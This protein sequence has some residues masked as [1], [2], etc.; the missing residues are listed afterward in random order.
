MKTF[1]D[2][3]KSYRKQFN[4]TQ[5][6]FADKINVSS[7][8]VSNWERNYSQPTMKELIEI[9]DSLCISL[10]ELVGKNIVISTIN[11]SETKSFGEQFKDIR[12]SNGYS[13]ARQL[14]MKSGISNAT[15]TRLENNTQKP[16]PNTLKILSQYLINTTYEELLRL[17][18]Y[19]NNAP[20]DKSLSDKEK[21]L[22]IKSRKLSDNQLD[23]LLKLMDEMK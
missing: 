20:E 2:N 5:K 23:I 16:D 12:I 8:V 13:S 3:L 15:I 6:E 11:P 4:L 19:V 14:S 9:A 10:D 1:A 17:S 18:G 21:E 22:L 7:Q